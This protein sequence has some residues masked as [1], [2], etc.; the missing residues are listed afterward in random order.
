MIAEKQRDFKTA[1][2]WYF[3]SLAIWEKEGDRHGAASISGQLGIIA[4]L[5]GRFTEGG[6]WLTRC[7]ASFKEIHDELGADRN[8][9][10]FQ[11]LHRHASPEDK[12]KL[13]AIW[14]EAKLGPFP[15]ERN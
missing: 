15:T 1:R 11:L 9:A 13:E 3:K 4:G 7:I 14:R 12:Q 8:I 2:E 10:N 5:Q 6:G